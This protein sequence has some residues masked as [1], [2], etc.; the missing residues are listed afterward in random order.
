MSH[1]QAPE[2]IRELGDARAREAK[3]NLVGAARQHGGLRYVRAHE[4]RDAALRGEHVRRRHGRGVL[5]VPPARAVALSY[6]RT[7]PPALV[8][9][10]GVHA[11]LRTVTMHVGVLTQMLL[12]TSRICGHGS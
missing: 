1:L 8:S 4:R 10:P 7:T 11:R 6:A 9:C 12:R 3:G 5:D 2:Q